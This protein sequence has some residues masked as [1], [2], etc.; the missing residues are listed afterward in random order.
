[1]CLLFVVHS[2]S[3]DAVVV[4]DSVNIV[5]ALLLLESEKNFFFVFIRRRRKKPL[6]KTSKRIDISTKN[7]DWQ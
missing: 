4:F 7:L 2:L 6:A 1:M 5:L 3:V